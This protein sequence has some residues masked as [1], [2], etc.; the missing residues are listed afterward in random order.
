MIAPIL[1]IVFAG[2]VLYAY[3]LYPLALVILSTGKKPPAPVEDPS[4]STLPPVSLLIAALDEEAIIAE[5]IENSL[6]LDYP[7]GRLRVVV[8]SDGSTDR[9]DEIVRRYEPRGVT[10]FRVEPREG[11]SLARNRAAGAAT[12]DVLVMSDANAMYES[13]AIRIENR[14]HSII[15]ANGSIYAIRRSLYVPLPAEVDDDFLEPLQAFLGGH[16]VRYEPE[17]VSIE[18]DIES[19]NV[20]RE[21]SAKRRTVLRGIQSLH[22]LSKVAG[23]FRPPA[24]AFELV[25][26]KILKWLVPFFLI[27]IL[28]ANAVLL[29]RPVFVA[30]FAIQLFLYGWAIAGIATGRRIFYIPAFFVLTN[31]AAFSGVIAFLAG[32]RSRTWRKQRE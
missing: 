29:D 27:G 16:G 23:P 10:L 15:G 13:D 26:H 4:D 32:R 17:A 22:Y 25:S 2:A 18:H 28:A 19:R 21:F 5:K 30:A 9:T 14:F 3:A 31:A 7:K 6:R 1:F 20:V 11:K 12:G 24:L 8:V